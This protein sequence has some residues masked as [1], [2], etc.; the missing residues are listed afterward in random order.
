MD[1]ASSDT[2]I[3]GEGLGPG[4][5][6]L[7]VGPS[8]AG[9]DSLIRAARDAFAGDEHYVF[10]RRYVTRPPSADEDSI[11]LT[12]G[13]FAALDEGGGFAVRWSAH[14]L[15]YGLPRAI[16]DDIAEGRAVICNV[17]RSVVDGLRARYANTLVVEVTAPAAVLAARLVARGRASDGSLDRRRD[18]NAM[19]G[20]DFRPDTTVQNADVLSV[21][22]AAFVE[23]I[24]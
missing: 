3:A 2:T 4:R 10:P 11:G 16:D 1:A 24:R 21:A 14:G 6:V 5:L 20:S 18:R 8:G 9:K 15:S 23:T 7:V 12:E 19:F 17:S 22:A 13:A